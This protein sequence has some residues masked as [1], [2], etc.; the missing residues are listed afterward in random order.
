[1]VTP[2][3]MTTL[4]PSQQFSPIL[5]GLEYSLPLRPLRS[6]GETGCVAVKRLTF[7]PSMVLFPIVTGIHGQLVSRR[8]P[9]G[10][11]SRTGRDLMP[12]IY[13]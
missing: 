7:G 5:I 4:P 3:Q 9:R 8:V 11:E 1:M 13:R 2:G 6:S 10:Q 12:T